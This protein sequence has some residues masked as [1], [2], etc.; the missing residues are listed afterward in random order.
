MYGSKLNILLYETIRRLIELVCLAPTGAVVLFVSIKL[1]RSAPDLITLALYILLLLFSVA[2]IIKL[3][4]LTQNAREDWHQKALRIRLALDNRPTIML[5]RP[6]NEDDLYKQSYEVHS[7][8][9]VPIEIT[10]SRIES[11]VN[12]LSKFG[13]VLAV[14]S[15]EF[16]G[17]FL[18]KQPN[19]VCLNIEADGKDAWLPTV[20]SLCSTVNLTVIAPSSTYG[21]KMEIETLHDSGMLQRCLFFMPEIDTPPRDSYDMRHRQHS[22]PKFEDEWEKV[23]KDLSKRGLKLP[24]FAE[25]GTAFFQLVS[26]GNDELTVLEISVKDLKQT[27]H[28]FRDFGMKGKDFAEHWA[29]VDN[30]GTIRIPT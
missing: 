3:K 14:G 4:D 21:S 23:R 27:L 28:S 18:N 10:S 6:F 26:N 22:A 13:I 15:L 17:I 20:M 30:K 9:T 1:D 12:T 7:S 11:L 24:A 19:A 16:E 5:L 8:E 29:V 2:W 25:I